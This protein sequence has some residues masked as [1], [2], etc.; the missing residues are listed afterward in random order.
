M[1]KNKI[2]NRKNNRPQKMP[3]KTGRVSECDSNN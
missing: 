3:N 2:D 1:Y